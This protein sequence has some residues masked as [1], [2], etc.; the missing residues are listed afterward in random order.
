MSTLKLFSRTFANFSKKATQEI[1]TKGKKC[2][3]CKYVA[4]AGMSEFCTKVI[5]DNFH[6][7]T[8]DTTEYARGTNG[9]C[10]AKAR[11]FTPKIPY[12]RTVTSS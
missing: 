4:T 8:F 6:S 7:L 1:P 5:F 12:S 11:W 9:P 3:D 2:V 10:G